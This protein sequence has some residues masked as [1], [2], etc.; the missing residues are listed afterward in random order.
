MPLPT[1][2]VVPL[3]GTIADGYGPKPVFLF[4]LGVF[5]AGSGLCGLAQNMPEIVA[6]RTL[7]GVGAGGL[8]MSLGYALFST[9]VTLYLAG[10]LTGAA[11][12]ADDDGELDTQ[13]PATLPY[14]PRR[15]T[16]SSRPP[17]WCSSSRPSSR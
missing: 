17:T 8:G 14:G 3:Y 7:Q 6:F 10:H 13:V 12:A 2:I 11:G 5:P 9:I 1:C 4:A 16:P 15:S